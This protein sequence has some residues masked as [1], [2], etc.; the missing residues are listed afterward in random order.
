MALALQK[1]ATMAGN[2]S[3]IRESLSQNEEIGHTS[4]QRLA[5]FETTRSELV[6]LYKYLHS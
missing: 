6:L 2:E 5:A 1:L 4:T 3:D